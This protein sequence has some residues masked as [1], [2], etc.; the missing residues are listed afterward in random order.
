M[1]T[2]AY[3]L[4]GSWRRRHREA[5]DAYDIGG[6]AETFPQAESLSSDEVIGVTDPSIVASQ[7]V[8]RRKSRRATGVGKATLEALPARDLT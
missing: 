2:S 4:A 6:E 5:C 8:I 1:P 3:L 7:W